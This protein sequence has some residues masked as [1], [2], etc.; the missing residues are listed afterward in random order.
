MSFMELQT[1]VV[2]V[3]LGEG[4][5]GGAL[6][7]GVCDDLA[8]LENT[9]YSVINPRGFASILWKDPSREKEA[10]ELMKISAGELKTAGIC[11]A[12][13]TEE[14]SVE[15]TAVNLR[16]YLTETLSRLCAEDP[17]ALP[18]KRYGRFRVMGEF[19]E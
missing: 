14:A 3:V 11:N 19:T 5:S 4:G 8:M 7:L 15:G 1:P 2:S 16:S 18:A 6:A 12:V 17:A 13:I 9:L 10:A